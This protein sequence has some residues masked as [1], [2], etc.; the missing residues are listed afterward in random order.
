MDGAI[1]RPT[2]DT[3]AAGSSTGLLA[4]SVR[5]LVAYGN[6][7]PRGA[8]LGLGH[9]KREREKAKI[10]AESRKD[11]ST[12]ETLHSVLST[13]LHSVFEQQKSPLRREP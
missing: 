10:W 9:R 4:T 7:G 6:K 5:Q 3:A 2:P 1:N 11:F 13:N 8:G 12:M